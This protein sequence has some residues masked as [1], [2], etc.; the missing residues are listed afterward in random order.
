MKLHI[1]IISALSAICLLGSIA[2]FSAVAADVLG[3]PSG[4]DEYTEQ[5]PAADPV[6]FDPGTVEPVTPDPGYT[7]PTEDPVYSEP[8][9]DPGY[10]E[11]TAPDPKPG[12]EE[13][14][15]EGG[16]TA[17]G[18]TYSATYSDV[19]SEGNFPQPGSTVESSAEI[20]STPVVDNTQQY[21]QYI[22]NNNMA[23]YDDNYIYVPE[24]TEPTE[25][26]ISTTSKVIDTD[27]LTKSDWDSI[28]LDL[29]NGNLDSTGAQ[30]FAFIKDNEE[31]G[32]T[33]MMWLVY[34]GTALIIAAVMMVIFVI[35]TTTK[36]NAKTETYYYA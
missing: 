4:D 29:S 19:I 11:S 32:D 31:E 35:V 14:D 33:N 5:Q 10:T 25:S 12:Y 34:L 3:R 2:C 18:S 6:P 13:E 21:N 17:S 24:Y 7:E 1:K 36:A 26:L 22:Y 8:T 15:G 16:E 20:A 9:Y 30:T 27:E 28:M 23:Q